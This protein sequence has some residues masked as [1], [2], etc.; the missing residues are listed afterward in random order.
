MRVE[1]EEVVLIGDTTRADLC[2]VWRGRNGGYEL[3]GD[4]LQLDSM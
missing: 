4:V 3:I 1:E 2:V